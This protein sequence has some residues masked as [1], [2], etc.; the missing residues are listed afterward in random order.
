M[1]RPS[2]RVL[3][4][5]DSA[6]MRKAI[7]SLLQKGPGIEVIDTA[8]NGIEAIEKA[9]TLRPD[10]VTL[11]V[12]MPEMDG[13][14][15][16]R[17]IKR[18]C[19]ARVIMISSLT[20][21][22]SQVTLKALAL[23]ADDFLA[24]AASTTTQIY[25]LGPELIEKVQALTSGRT[26][27]TAPPPRRTATPRLRAND[28]DLLV[29][30]SSTGGPP[31]LEKIITS[32]PA[33]FALPVVIAQH[34]PELFTRSMADRLDA[35]SPLKVLH[36]EQGAPIDIGQV[37][38]APGGR[39]TKVRRRV[40]GLGL[41]IEIGDEPRSATYRPSVDE[42]FATSAAVAGRRVLAVVLTGMGA[43]GLEGGKLLHAAG[44]TLL[45][46]DEASCV[47]YGMPK[48][49]TQAGITAATLTPDEMAA[50]LRSLVRSARAA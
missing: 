42:L 16:L 11:D 7:A 8:R 31:I 9:R 40:G 21:E 48:A 33:D 26:P 24:K 3:V 1:N 12:E 34:M 5:D 23:G 17:Q 47:V 2:V 29:I 37:H 22:G 6:F 13:I 35:L 14:T 10:L 39:H 50:V 43:D 27:L 45:A 41:R 4:V 15:A 28:Y 19:S 38:V 30:G 44:G 49:V 25:S 46:Q 32:L 18:V 20:T 36:A